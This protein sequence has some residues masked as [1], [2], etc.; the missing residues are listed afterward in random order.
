MWVSKVLE[1]SPK[2]IHRPQLPHKSNHLQIFN[3]AM[4]HYTILYCSYKHVAFPSR[5]HGQILSMM[6]IITPR[7]SHCLHITP[8]VK[9]VSL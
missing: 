1:A 9:L 7:P 8:Q 5:S 4:M 2:Y 6:Y 3:G